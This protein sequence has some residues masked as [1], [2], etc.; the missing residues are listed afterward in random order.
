MTPEDQARQIIAERCKVDLFYLVKYILGGGD[1]IDPRVHGPVCKSFRHLVFK[2]NPEESLK[3][4]F[5]SDYGRTEEEGIGTEADHLAFEEWQK[6]FE[7]NVDAAHAVRDKVDINLTS[8]LIMLPRGTLKTSIITI[9]GAIQWLL[10]YG[11]DR[12]GLDS[13]T[14]TKTRGFLTEIK[15][16]FEGND[17][18]REVYHTIYGMYPDDKSKKQ[19]WS[20]EMIVMPSRTRARK[21][22]SIDCLGIGTTRNGFHYD[23]AFLDD[24]HS[25][26]NTK[27][28]EEINR[29]KEHRKLVYSLLDPGAPQVVICTRWAFSDAYQEII[30]E[31]HEDFNFITRSAMSPTGNLF[32]PSRL[33]ARTLDRFKRLLGPY[34]YSCQYLNN[35]TDT[36]DAT[37]VRENF[38]YMTRDQM[39]K[40]KINWYGLV[41]PSYGGP[42]SDY[43]AIVIA[44]VDAQGRYYVKHILRKKMT[45]LEIIDEMFRLDSIFRP[46][47]WSMEVIGTKS[48]EHTLRDKEREKGRSLRVHLIKSRSRAKVERIKSLAAFYDDHKIWHC[49]GAPGI[50]DLEDELANFPRA[51][52]DD[53]SDCLADILEIGI[54]P[55]G[56]EGESGKSTGGNDTS[57]I[58]M[59]NKPRSPTVG[60]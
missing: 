5:P 18:L 50:I 32:Y 7:P 2:K 59:L 55:R 39:S 33:D 56:D 17:K 38:Q 52:H 60:Y 21:E 47:R 48:L 20:T 42:S 16:H 35:P 22:P 13:E 25:E 44:G 1:L 23:I 58:T 11:E 53:V 8:L 12:V 30:D 3:Y 45:Y 43:C 41:D 36:D 28:T 15:G 24:L 9:G 40:R 10:N 49:I 37:F 14:V 26:I 6:Q 54:R 31:E 29:V 51:K 34:L 4:Q 46:A 57:Y 27:S 19:Q